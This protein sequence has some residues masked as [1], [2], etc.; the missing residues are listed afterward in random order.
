MLCHPATA[1]TFAW[2]LGVLVFVAAGYCVRRA[3]RDTA[4]RPFAWAW[5]GV[6]LLVAGFLVMGGGPAVLRFAVFSCARPFSG[7]CPRPPA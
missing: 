4:S 7:A 6:F 5:L 2:L 1:L 3:R